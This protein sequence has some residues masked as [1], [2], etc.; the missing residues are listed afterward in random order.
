MERYIEMKKYVFVQKSVCDI[1][2]AQ[3][4]LYRKINFLKDQGFDVRVIVGVTGDIIIEKLAEYDNVVEGINFSPCFFN[5]RDQKRIIDAAIKLIDPREGEEIY[6][7]SCTASTSLWCEM[8]AEKLHCRHVSFDFEEVFTNLTKTQLEFHNFKHLRRELCGISPHALPLMFKGYKEIPPEEAYCYRAMCS[9]PIDEV[10]D[11]EKT[12]ALIGKLKDYDC[13]IG[14]IGRAEKPFLIPTLLGILDYI[15][16]KPDTRFAVLFIGGAEQKKYEEEA[17]A[18]FENVEN[19]SF[20]CTGRIFPIPRSL[21]KMCAA[22][23]SSSGSASATARENIPT[24]AVSPSTFCA[25]GI[26][27]YTT[28]FAAM[29]EKETGLSIE[30]QLAEII[31]NKYCETHENLGLY[32]GISFAEDA[33]IQFAKQ[34]DF[35]VNNES[36]LEYYDVGL[37]KKEGKTKLVALAARILGSK[38]F[39]GALRLLEKSNNTLIKG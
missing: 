10:T 18:V 11:S 34:V 13:V 22:F 4:Y 39:L 3:Q 37:V 20:Y 27:N 1:G 21:A 2:G 14:T 24:V 5:K 35:V 36:P 26:L 16:S 32:D 19:A 38:I 8:I 30:S 29:P 15:K 9:D 17:A 33:K 12:N 6:I 28:K 7:E 23:V 31:E 25:N